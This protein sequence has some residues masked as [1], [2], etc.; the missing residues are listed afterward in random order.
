LVLWIIGLSGAGKTTL[1]NAVV[2]KLRSEGKKI[3]VLDG[4]EVRKLYG[5]DLGFDLASRRVNS[6]RIVA[7]C[8]FL[9]RQGIHVVCSVLSLFPEHRDWCRNN[10][11]GYF[12]V[13]VKASQDS[14]RGRDIKGIYEKYDAGKI[15]NVAGLDIMFPV[16]TNPDTIIENDGQLEDFTN[17]RN[18]LSTLFE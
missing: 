10:L 13:Y 5:D 17:N 7:L 12:E 9:D 11:T 4:D 8:E 6:E 3:V 1:A 14:L 16:P 18:Y 15:T 2:S